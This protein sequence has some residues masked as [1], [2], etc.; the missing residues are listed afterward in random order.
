MHFN[1]A[2][3]TNRENTQKYFKKVVDNNGKLW[4]H[5]QAV[6]ETATEKVR[7]DEI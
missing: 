2:I 3:F 5:N 1:I 6:T 7:K 4:Y